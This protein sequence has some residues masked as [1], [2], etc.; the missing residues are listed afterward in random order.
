MAQTP[1]DADAPGERA[2]S[3]ASPAGLD[4]DLGGEVDVDGLQ[5][6]GQRLHGEEQR[7]RAERAGGVFDLD[8]YRRFAADLRRHQAA[9]RRFR[10]GV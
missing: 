10:T 4:V 2:A 9:V 8:A 7:L 6:E 5:A 3:T 1:G